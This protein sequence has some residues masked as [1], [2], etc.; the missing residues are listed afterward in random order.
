M[1]QVPINIVER[2]V[3]AYMDRGDADVNADVN[4]IHWGRHYTWPSSQVRVTDC[5]SLLQAALSPSFLLLLVCLDL[6]RA[7]LL[8]M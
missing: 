3:D 5:P 1:F 2:A 6:F 7:G 8:V 4:G